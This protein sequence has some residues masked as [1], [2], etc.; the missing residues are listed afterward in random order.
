MCSTKRIL[1][2]LQTI[3]V[4]KTIRLRNNVYQFCC[5]CETFQNNVE[6][7]GESDS[8][9]ETVFSRWR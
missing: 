7:Q 9:V 6:D 5:R 4:A 8:V 1:I 2:L 3:N